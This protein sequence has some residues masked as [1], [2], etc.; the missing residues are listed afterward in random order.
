MMVFIVVISFLALTLLTVI[1]NYFTAPVLT[2]SAVIGEDVK[3]VSVLIPARNEEKNVAKCLKKVLSQDYSNFEVLVLDD[4][5]TDSTFEILKKFQVNFNNLKIIK[6]ENLPVIWSG[7]NWACHQLSEKAGGDLLLFMDADVELARTAISSA[8]SE[9]KNSNLKML[10]VFPTQKIETFYEWLI[11]PLMNWLLLSFL[12]L[13][14]VYSSKNKSFVAANG[15]FMLWDKFTYLAVGGHANVYNKVVEDM[16]LARNTKAHGFK[17]KTLLGGNQIFCRMYDNFHSAYLGYSKN[18]WPG[19]NLNA[20]LFL[21]LIS[22]LAFAFIIPVVLT[23]FSIKF[24][25]CVLILLG[26]RILISKRS[27][28]NIL[29][30]RLLHPVQMIFMFLIG[31]NSILVTKTNRVLWKDRKLIRTT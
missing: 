26:E 8:V 4:K 6:G 12:P 22:I 19:F 10:S 13:K 30:N 29:P 3:K 20:F 31:V 21:V 11:V 5:S 17:I 14:K 27:R 1:Y 25:F 9:M 15:Q 7:K 18:F 23:F 24:F 2:N 28:Q 16:E